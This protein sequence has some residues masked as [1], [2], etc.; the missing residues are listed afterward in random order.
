MIT[1][2]KCPFCDSSSLDWIVSDRREY[3]RCRK[4]GKYFD[5]YECAE[6]AIDF[7]KH[8]VTLNDF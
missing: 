1:G 3:A 4:C 7:K 8:V 5:K 2:F 6:P